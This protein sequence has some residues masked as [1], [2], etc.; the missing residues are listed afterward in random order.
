MTTIAKTEKAY[1]AEYPSDDAYHNDRSRL[2]GS[3]L[4][5]FDENPRMF[6]SWRAGRWSQE[7]TPAMAFGSLFHAL[8]LEPDTVDDRFAIE[9]EDPEKPGKCIHRA[10]KIYKE[11][12]AATEKSGKTVVAMDD[13]AKIRPMASALGAMPDVMDLLTCEGGMNEVALHFNV[14]EYGRPMRAKLDR[15]IPDRDIIVELKTCRSAKPTEKNAWEWER[16][17]YARKAWLY[18]YAYHQVFGRHATMIHIFVE[19]DTSHPQVGWFWT[20]IDSPAAQWGEIEALRVLGEI[21]RCEEAEDFRASFEP[22]APGEQTGPLP[23]PGPIVSKLEFV[24]DGPAEL[25]VGGQMVRL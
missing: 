6:A 9:P 4:D 21:Q 1:L 7:T 23:I 22:G 18:L 5:L 2:S 8:V 24:N 20:Q 11:W 10:T 14:E 3:N 13:I 16:L 15:I 25:D 12:R 19:K 17:G